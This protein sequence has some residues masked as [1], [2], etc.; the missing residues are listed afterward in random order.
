MQPLVRGKVSETNGGFA[1]GALVM[2]PIRGS[3]VA[4][5]VPTRSIRL[6][7]EA[8]CFLYKNSVQAALVNREAKW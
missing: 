2:K 1:A 8:T 7:S 3:R 6:R 4:S 5:H